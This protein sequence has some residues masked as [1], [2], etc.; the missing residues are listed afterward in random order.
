MT[1]VSHIL[2]TFRR[3]ERGAA[4]VELGMVIPLFLLLM[5]GIVDYGRLFWSTTMAQKAMQKASRLATL[6]PPLCGALPTEHTLASGAPTSTKFGVLCRSGNVCAVPALPA[7]CPLNTATDYGARV[8]N[9]I[10]MLLPPGTTAA[11]VQIGYSHDARLGFLGG[12]Y[13]PVV[14]AELVNVNFNF[15]MP[16]AGLAAL[17]SNGTTPASNTP[18]SISLPAMSTSVPAEDLAAGASE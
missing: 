14:T 4:L 13:T 15:M 11:N 17:A 9:D 10:R 3:Q 8:W 7:P 2:R 6:G 12:P 16:I 18:N 1:R 5:F